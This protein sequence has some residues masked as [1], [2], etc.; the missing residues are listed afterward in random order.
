[1]MHP[2]LRAVRR[3]LRS[4]KIIIGEIGAI[5]FAGVLGATVPQAGIAS[6]AETAKFRDA[7]PVLRALVKIFSLDHIFRSEWFL[8]L[9]AAAAASLS[10][11]VVEQIRRVRTQWA[12]GPAETQFKSAPYRIEFERPAR[13][14]HAQGEGQP[15]LEVRTQHRLGILGSPLFHIG[16]L[17]VILAG[18]LRSLFAV[19][20][21]VDLIEGETLPPTAGAWAAQWPGL[22]VKP[23]RLDYPITLEAVRAKFYDDGQLMDLSSRLS[24]QTRDGIQ[25]RDI[26]IN[27]ELAMPGGR[28][29]T[30][31]NFGPAALLEWKAP[32][33]DTIREAALLKQAGIRSFEGSSAGPGEIRAHVRAGIAASGN[34]PTQL[35]VRIMNGRSL[36]FA[37]ALRPGEDL[38]LPG[39][40]TLRLYGMPFWSRLHGSRDPE[41]WLLYAGFL[42]STAGAVVIFCFVKVDTCVRV[43]PLGDREQVF[44]ALT[45]QRFAP[46]FR[47]RFERLVRD[48]GG[49]A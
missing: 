22:L 3:F 48:Q 14:T 49:T 39:G 8:L 6:A 29:F 34:R 32:G 25:K 37:G 31:S 20:A 30:D 42:L 1:M 24:F 38:S 26:A 47:E 16:L 18:V 9:L 4:P 28:L 40:Q 21:M 15:S 17:L 10:I 46:L 43:T 23:F 33:V 36:V 11:V 27:M 41:L 5:L 13:T 19:D 44:V 2:E 35:D 7:G 12:R 45:S